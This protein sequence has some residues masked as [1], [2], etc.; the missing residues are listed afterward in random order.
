MWTKSVGI[1]LGVTKGPGRAQATQIGTRM[2]VR[3][4]TTIP[5]VPRTPDDEVLTPLEGMYIR[6]LQER[7]SLF[8]FLNLQ[9]SRSDGHRLWEN[10]F[11]P[12]WP[13]PLLEIGS[14]W[15][16]SIFALEKTQTQR[17][18]R[19]WVPYALPRQILQSHP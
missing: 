4:G 9:S 12:L 15:V 11:R 16:H 17:Y 8:R 5:I 10:V 13:K 7:G 6:S 2:S 19:R 3:Q 18:V 1:F 14:I